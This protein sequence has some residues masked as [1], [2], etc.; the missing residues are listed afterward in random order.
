MKGGLTLP[1]ALQMAWATCCR[2][3]RRLL[4]R[5]IQ[6]GPPVNVADTHVLD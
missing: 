2:A 1:K 6:L 4:L 3:S 5:A